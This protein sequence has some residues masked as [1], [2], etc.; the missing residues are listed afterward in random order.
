MSTTLFSPLTLPCGVV[1]KNRIIKSAM[2][3]SLGDG[4]GHPTD[5]QSKLY[6]RWAKGGLAASIIGEV[7]CTPD[8]AEKP[9][10]LVLDDNADLSRFKALAAA[11]REN[12]AQLWIQLGHAGALAYAP[13]SNPVGPS[14]LNMVGL[15]CSEISLDDLKAVP[16][17]FARTA[18]LAKQ[19]GFSGVQI[20]AAHGFLLS[21]FL[22]PLFNKRD[23]DYGGSIENRMRLLLE[24]I[25][26]V[27][28]AVGPDFPIAIK[29]NSSD[30]LEGGLAEA[31]ALKI[32][33]TLDKTSVD[34][35]DISGGTYFPGAKSASDGSA[36]GPYFLEFATAAR[37]LTSKPLM[38]TGG[39][40]TRE[41]VED[42]LT[43]GVDLIGLA[44][45]LII[46][47]SLPE[48]WQSD[49][50]NDPTFPRFSEAPEGGITAWYTMQMTAI[51]EGNEIAVSGNLSEALED[52]EK[53]DKARTDV[54]LRHFSP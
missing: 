40:K 37:S 48:I 27:R 20:H 32:V 38:L 11:G 28:A 16:T 30:Q 33:E 34:L 4:T 52:Y 1:L 46:E 47:P 45:A 7:Q 54:W 5:G 6:R 25:R 15:S 44:R 21:Q 8:F 36:K 35:I 10:N 42:A 50:Q 17:E 51:A 41:Q 39:F 19:V 22:S 24:S 12:D 9:G 2:S 13:T 3:D 49:Q 18:T 43:K 29:L 31:D 53:R 14:A 26:S 23:D